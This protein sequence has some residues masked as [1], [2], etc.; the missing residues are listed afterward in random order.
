MAIIST[1]VNELP[2]AQDIT[3]FEIPGF[4]LVT[5]AGAKATMSTLKGDKG[6]APNISVT[7]VALPYGSTPTVTKTGT[8][9]NPSFQ[10]GFP[11]AQNGKT[12]MFQTTTE[13]IQYR[14]DVSEPW[15]NLIAVDD[16]RL[17]YSDLSDADKQ[18]IMQPAL[19]AA[20]TA[21]E[22]AARA[23]TAAAN[24]EDATGYVDSKLA[25]YAT[26]DFVNSS[27]Q[28]MAAN[29]VTY[30]A[31]GNAFPTRNSLLSA[32]VVYFGG[33]AYT[34][35]QHDY[36]TIIADE[37]A[38]T[39]YTGGQT[40]L[41]F[42]GTNWVWQEGV[43]ERPFTAAENAAI[44]SGITSDIVQKIVTTDGV[45]TISG[46]KTFTQKITGSITGDAG[47]VM[48]KVPAND[49]NV[50]EGDKMPI[51]GWSDATSTGGA[52]T[53]DIIR[54]LHLPSAPNLTD[55]W[56]N[57]IITAD[58]YGQLAAI[59]NANFLADISN[60]FENRQVQ[61][62]VEDG[63]SAL[64]MAKGVTYYYTTEQTGGVTVSINDL[65]PGSYYELLVFGNTPITW[66]GVTVFEAKNIDSSSATPMPIS[67]GFIYYCVRVLQNNTIW[68]NASR[69]GVK[70]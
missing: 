31:A 69:Y 21:N 20:T 36:A 8:N 19:T 27:I 40:R 34:P 70:Q 54:L 35:S 47:S 6:D 57:S 33:V 4:D 59:T 26:K 51:Y 38:P 9:E 68:M 17:H 50:P 23:N 61:T 25:D 56:S 32:T 14:F 60:R 62:L 46:T 24:A 66:S 10:I 1:R 5:N 43:N 45:Q 11:L 64:S 12:P 41:E 30:D 18:E 44:G 29:R 16:I 39:P 28:S 42:D 67:G 53:A 13:Y 58:Q 52:L 3:R 55:Y 65:T 48:G 22:A 49:T 15:Q 7:M 2:V 63:R 37:A